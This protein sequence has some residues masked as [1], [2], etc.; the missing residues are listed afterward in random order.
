MV[1]LSRGFGVAVA[2]ALLVACGSTTAPT[3]E[4]A[5]RER[6]ARPPTPSVADVYTTDAS[7]TPVL[8]PPTTAAAVRDAVAAAARQADVAL[9]GDGRLAG[10]AGELAAWAARHGPR[11][12]HELIEAL[13]RRSGLVEPAPHLL[14]VAGPPDAEALAGRVAEGLADLLPRQPYNRFGAAV[15][16]DGPR[17]LVV[18]ALSA[19]WLRLVPLPRRVRAGDAVVLEAIVEAP[20]E[21]PVVVRQTPDGEVSRRR[22]RGAGPAFAVPLRFE[23]PGVHRVELIAAGPRGDTVLAN[24]P[25]FVGVPPDPDLAGALAAPPEPA[26]GDAAAVA[27]ELRS[28]LAA[29]RADAGVPPLEVDATLSDVARAHGRDMVEHG[30]VGHRSPTTGSAA[31]RVRAA[32]ARATL[33]LEN[34]GRG[35][36]ARGIHRG[37]MGSPGHRANLLNPE[38]TH[39]GIG[40]V[41][42]PEGD[43]TAFVAT[44]VL[45][46]LS[47]PVDVAAA[48]DRLRASLD[49]LR[50]A[51][52]LPAVRREPALDRAAQ[53]AAERF[54]AEP[55]IDGRRLV[56]EAAAALP[57][58]RRYRR[59]GGALALVGD[60]EQA[61]ALEALQDRQLAAVGVGVA[62]GVR[63]DVPFGTL[64]VVYLFAWPR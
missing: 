33:V 30:F 32:G 52:G 9:E 47:A 48:P 60:L 15:L 51:R 12:P 27:A 13:A 7:P 17:R 46:R 5:E 58:I 37:L 24:F 39:L 40:V 3:G 35:Y 45:A 57:R 8:G 50:R 1:P 11:P 19:R 4:A 53:A 42:E 41:A 2:A 49:A 29:A 61:G 44:Q 14:V 25:V 20:Y 38:V 26:P 56:D 31:D 62:E 55:D 6:A 63:E 16:D 28:L 59:V 18:V 21:G 43:R 10:V 22:P 36:G 23:G 54:F 34:I 64:A